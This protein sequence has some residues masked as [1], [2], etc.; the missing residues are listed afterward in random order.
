MI[1]GL[2]PEYGLYTAIVPPVVAALF[3]SSLHLISGPTTA[4]SI[5]VFS[6]LSPIAE[7]GS[8]EFIQLALTLAFVTG[9]YQMVLGL[10]RMGALV[11]FVSHSV[12]VGFAGAALL[13]VTSQ[14]NYLLS[15]TPKGGS[16]LG[17]WKNIFAEI[18]YVNPHVLLVALVTLACAVLFKTLRPTWPGLLPALLAGSLISLIIDGELHGVQLMGSLP[19]VLPPFSMP[20]FS[21]DTLRELAPKGLAM[22]CWVNRGI[23]DRPSISTHSHQ[24]IDGNRIYG[25][26]LSNMVGS[27]SV[28]R[29]GSFTR[30]GINYNAGA[31]TPLLGVFHQLSWR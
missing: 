3:G 11:N 22:P 12:V 26:G 14:L 2:P 31:M 28:T 15:L 7:P 6:S 8:A 30:S 5:V 27:F 17:T 21:I 24:Q 13:I 16:F 19:A 20:D 18:Y 10:A 25:Q 23:I 29:I 9:I 1:A 4:I